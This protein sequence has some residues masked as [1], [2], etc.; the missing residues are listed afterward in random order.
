MTSTSGAVVA[1][2]Q[3]A[4]VVGATAIAASTNKVPD[5]PAV[6]LHDRTAAVPSA[7]TVVAIAAVHPRVAHAELPP[8]SAPPVPR[9][10]EH[11]SVQRDPYVELEQAVRKQPIE[12]DP[13]IVGPG[14]AAAAV[15]KLKPIAY[16]PQKYG[17]EAS[18][19][20]YEIAVLLHKPLHQ[21]AEALHTLD[22]YRQRFGSRGKELAAALW[23]RV[24]VTC[25]HAIDDECREAAY[26]YQRAVPT[27]AATDV[28]IRITNAQ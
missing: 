15:A 22:F 12:L 23:L 2:A 18:R 17:E 27:G 20:L 8:P 10:I 19:A 28:A 26:S 3:D 24:R 25:G 9:T 4:P 21:D 13:K 1:S 7:P 6:T 11:A 14:D 16:A 5:V